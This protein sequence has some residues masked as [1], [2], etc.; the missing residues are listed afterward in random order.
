MCIS[1]VNTEHDVPLFCMS[2]LKQV[3][4]LHTVPVLVENK[5]VKI[6]LQKDYDLQMQFGYL[7]MYFCL[8]YLSGVSWKEPP[9]PLTHLPTP[10]MV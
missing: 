10:V 5:I 2:C 4:F 3:T 1:E 7:V 6:L 9:P 8:C